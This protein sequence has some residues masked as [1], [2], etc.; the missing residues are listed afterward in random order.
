MPDVADMAQ[1]VDSLVLEGD[2]LLLRGTDIP[3]GRVTAE[4][5]FGARIW[6]VG[7]EGRTRGVWAARGFDLQDP[8]PTCASDWELQADIDL[9]LDHCFSLARSW[10]ADW[11]VTKVQPSGSAYMSRSGL[12]LL[13][14]PR[15]WRLAKTEGMAD[16]SV[17][18]GLRGLIPGWYTLGGHVLPR[19]NRKRWRLYFNCPWPSAPQLLQLVRDEG[20]MRNAPL[21]AKVAREHCSGRPIGFSSG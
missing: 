3:G 11:R 5:A 2:A 18:S 8:P 14:E 1:F 16:I 20:Q 19:S 6:A 10:W 21:I 15:F 9:G 12:T 4:E 13:V 17:P 7:T